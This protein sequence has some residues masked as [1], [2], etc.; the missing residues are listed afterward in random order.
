[1]IT[2]VMA[3]T[4]LT[5]YGTWKA[6]RALAGTSRTPPASVGAWLQYAPTDMWRGTR[7]VRRSPP[8]HAA[9]TVQQPR[10]SHH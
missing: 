6:C 3:D 4:M 9:V 2:F 8:G 1:M 7:A 5:V 10:C